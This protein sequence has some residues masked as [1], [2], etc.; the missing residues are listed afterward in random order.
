V[1]G[2][3]SNP[4]GRLLS[5]QFITAT[6]SIPPAPDELV[7]PASALAEDGDERII[8]TQRDAS[9][10]RY[11]LRHVQVLMRGRDEI[12][13][14]SQVP[15]RDKGRSLGPFHQGGRIATAGT[16]EMWAELRSFERRAG[17]LRRSVSDR[18][19]PVSGGPP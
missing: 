10:P 15:P 13:I 14:S 9:E 3:V 18:A 2:Q 16:L 7:I 5:G 12:H 19:G 4:E 11:T 8:F 6:V 1:K 17:D